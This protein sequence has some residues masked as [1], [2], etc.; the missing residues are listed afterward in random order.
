LTREHIVPDKQDLRTEILKN[1]IPDFG[2]ETRV[3]VAK[4][5]DL[6]QIDELRKCNAHQIFIFKN[7]DEMASH[8]DGSRR[9][10][11]LEVIGAQEDIVL[12][13]P[14]P[15]MGKLL[16]FGIDFKRKWEAQ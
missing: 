3:P 6:A 15:I 14:I 8:I 13:Q 16:G 7:S 2:L 11:Y 9:F 1:H 4:R 12:R 5:L 10:K